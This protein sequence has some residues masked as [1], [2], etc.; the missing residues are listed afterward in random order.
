MSI[1]LTLVVVI[2]V[3]SVLYIAYKVASELKDSKMPLY[4][5]YWET[6]FIPKNRNSAGTEYCPICIKPSADLHECLRSTTLCDDCLRLVHD[7]AVLQN[8]KFRK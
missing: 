8:L 2:V 1:E 7:K 5:K 3:A 4:Q 6:R